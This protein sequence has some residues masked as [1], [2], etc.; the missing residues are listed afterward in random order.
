MLDSAKLGHTN[1]RY[2]TESRG[3]RYQTC[4][5]VTKSK[6][7]QYA[8]SKRSRVATRPQSQSA[9]YVKVCH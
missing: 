9:G 2:L 6:F 1:I 8:S 4:H 5:P 7:L 3:A